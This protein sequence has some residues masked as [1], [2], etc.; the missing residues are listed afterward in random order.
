MVWIKYNDRI[1][2]KT[3]DLEVSEEVARFLW[4]NDRYWRRL[5]KKVNKYECSYFASIFEDGD[6]IEF[7]ETIKD[8]SVDIEQEVENKIF[9]EVIWKVAEKLQPLQK[10]VLFERFKKDMKLCDIAKKHNMSKSALTQYLKTTD[11]FFIFFLAREKDFIKT[12]FW[13]SHCKDFTDEF[14]DT[15]EEG[16]TNENF[17][18]DLNKILD[19]AKGATQAIKI[20]D[21]LGVGL[22]QKEKKLWQFMSKTVTDFIKSIQK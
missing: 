5:M 15:L 13:Q 21:K 14:I 18:F 12:D 7:I 10:E 6:E 3:I 8:E 20:A 19:F 16:L 2:N 22:S 9:A 17:E 1:H 4:T 11:I